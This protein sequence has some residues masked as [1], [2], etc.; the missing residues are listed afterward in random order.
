MGPED[1]VGL[2]STGQVFNTLCLSAHRKEQ[3]CNAPLHLLLHPLLYSPSPQ[4]SLEM[5][6][7]KDSAFRPSDS[8]YAN[9]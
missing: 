3:K 9:R 2:S 4:V 7:T 6:G 5:A 8:C 1:Q